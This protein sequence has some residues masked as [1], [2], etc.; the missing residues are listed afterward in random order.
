MY[1]SGL[2]TKGKKIFIPRGRREKTLQAAL[3]QYSVPEN[4]KTVIG[5]LRRRNR[6]DLISRME[7]L[8]AR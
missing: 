3:L 8:K 7:R 6:P 5:F 4:K 2:D 1:S